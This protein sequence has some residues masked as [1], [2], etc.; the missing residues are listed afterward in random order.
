MT[1]VHHVQRS[2]SVAFD[3]NLEYIHQYLGREA[4]CWVQNATMERPIDHT[5]KAGVAV[6][7]SLCP[8]SNDPNSF[9]D[10]IASVGDIAY[11]QRSVRVMLLWE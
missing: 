2:V 3:G 11:L 4:A 9:S 8:A 5:S 10:V 7:R 1:N 6:L